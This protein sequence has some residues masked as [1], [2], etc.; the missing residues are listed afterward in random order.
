MLLMSGVQKMQIH[1]CRQ[2]VFKATRTMMRIAIIGPLVILSCK[3]KTEITNDNTVEKIVAEIKQNTR[4]RGLTKIDI[5]KNEDFE[6]TEGLIEVDSLVFSQLTERIDIF[7]TMSSDYNLKLYYHGTLAFDDNF[8]TLVSTIKYDG[9]KTA[10][11]LIHYR[12]N[13]LFYVDKLS[14]TWMAVG[15]SGYSM[16]FIKGDTLTKVIVTSFDNPENPND[17]GQKN[18]TVKFIYTDSRLTKN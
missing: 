5:G 1:K 18:D 11:E 10:I 9:K 16:S 6:I 7:K 2:K 17:F 13:N 12:D 15:G 14:D 3:Q 4:T 8:I